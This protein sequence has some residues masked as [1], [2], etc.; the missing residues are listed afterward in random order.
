MNLGSHAKT[1]IATLAAAFA[2]GGAGAA[3]AQSSG[4]QG[5]A[6]AQQ[7]NCMSCHSVSRTFMG[8][9]LRDVAAKYAARPDA[10]SYLARK[11]TDGSSGVWGPVQMPANTQLSGAQAA[12]LASWVLSLK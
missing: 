11:I 10:Q 2:L 12:A 4:P 5:L 3:A 9:A 8:P 1:T 7:Q 6:L